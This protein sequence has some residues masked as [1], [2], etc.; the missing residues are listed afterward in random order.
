[1]LTFSRILEGNHWVCSSE[2]CSF[3]SGI[4]IILQELQFISL[5][6]SIF[7]YIH[8][9]CPSQSPDVNPK[10]IFFG[11]IGTQ[12]HTH[13]QSI[14]F[15]SFIC[16]GNWTM[17]TFTHAI[18]NSPKNI[19]L[20]IE[21]GWMETSRRQRVRWDWEEE[22]E[23]SGANREGGMIFFCGWGN[24]RPEPRIEESVFLMLELQNKGNV[25]VSGHGHWKFDMEI[26]GNYSLMTSLFR[27]MEQSILKWSW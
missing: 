17:H 22:R 6:Q 5:I 19:W 20:T 7:R 12:T 26:P 13:T 11:K 21:A 24:K 25:I 3:N 27:L 4:L 2:T 14:Y 15:Y 23:G 10:D 8:W 9:D 16:G 18:S 1:M